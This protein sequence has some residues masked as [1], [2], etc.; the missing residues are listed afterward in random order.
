[1]RILTVGAKWMLAA[2]LAERPEL[3]VVAVSSDPIPGFPLPSNLERIA[4]PRGSKVSWRSTMAVRQ[5]IRQ[6]RPDLI[7]AFYPRPLAHSLLAVSLSGWD[8]PLVSY[9]GITAR[10]SRWSP[11]E[12]VTYLSP[13]VAAHACE[14]GAVRDAMVTSGIDAAKCHVVYNCLGKPLTE[15]S[16]DQAR[17][18]LNLAADDWVVMMVAN[19]RKVKG[20]DILLEAAREC[21]D[22][23]RLKILLVGRVLDPQV[24]RLAA[25]PQLAPMVTLAGYQTDAAE[26]VAAAD[27]FVMPSRAEALSVALVE[28]MARG[29]CPVVSDA[30]GMKE[31]VRHEVD[32]LVFP[33]ENPSALASTLRHLAGHPELVAQFAASAQQRANEDFSPVAVAERLAA[34]YRQ[35][36]SGA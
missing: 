30:G 5:A 17:K 28:A 14:S 15:S 19:I 10:L 34:I 2:A 9:R 33:K 29:V 31:A 3:D 20:A 16:R 12:W 36:L 32:G 11:S 26:L 7:H 6:S 23:P 22:L 13:R 27:V 24:A 1:M 25:E 21:R 18:R 4:Y 35:L 8:I